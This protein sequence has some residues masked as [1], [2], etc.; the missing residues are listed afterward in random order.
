MDRRGLKRIGVMLTLLA[1]GIALFG[2][3]ALRHVARPDAV[4]EPVAGDCV[5]IERADGQAVY[6]VREE[7]L[8]LPL[9][10]HLPA[11]SSLK[12][13]ESLRVYA[14]KDDVCVNLA[15]VYERA[16]YIDWDEPVPEDLLAAIERAMTDK[17]LVSAYRLPASGPKRHDERMAALRADY[18]AQFFVPYKG[19]VLDGFYP[20]LRLYYTC[21]DYARS[22]DRSLDRA[23]DDTL[24][25]LNQH[26]LVYLAME[27]GL[28]A[29]FAGEN[30]FSRRVEL[31]L[32]DEADTMLL[33]KIEAILR[34]S[35]R[36]AP[37]A[38]PDGQPSGYIS[39]TEGRP[40]TI[41]MLTDAPLDDDVL[42]ALQTAHGLAYAAPG[43]GY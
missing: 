30:Y 25:W 41:Y 29:A 15:S 18:D 7:A 19:G 26:E 10:E 11:A 37:Y 13:S 28:S 33:D 21:Y 24:A 23:F 36:E 34:E 16:Q 12:E 2:C 42:A 39:Y 38:A 3:A 40:Y 27:P 6:R 20:S 17:N 31:R 8:L 43:E 22:D 1:S 32:Y 5:V 4:P 9:L 35:T 14:L